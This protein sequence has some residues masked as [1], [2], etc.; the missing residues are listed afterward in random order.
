MFLWRAELAEEWADSQKLLTATPELAAWTLASD[1]ITPCDVI[2]HHDGTLV[3]INRVVG[4]SFEVTRDTQI[5]PRV[6]SCNRSQRR[7]K[8]RIAKVSRS[9]RGF[10]RPTTIVGGK[11]SLGTLFKTSI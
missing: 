2:E 7:S 10:R 3:G 8:A 5:R 11:P 1:G 6:L 9:P 4:E